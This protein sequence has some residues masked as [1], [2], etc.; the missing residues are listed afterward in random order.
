MSDLAARV[1]VVR[2][3]FQLAVDLTLPAGQVVA[4]VGPN[5]AGKTTLVL[6]LLG[7]V[8][9][10]QGRIALGPDV[11]FDAS[12]GVD[13]PTEERRIGY[14]PQDYA[15]FPHLTAADNVGFA[16]ACRAPVPP[17]RQ[18]AQRARAL[19]E[20]VGAASYADRRPADLS[21]GER[22]RVA[23]ARALATDPRALLFDEPFAALDATARAEVRAYLRARLGELAL[24]ALVITHDRDDVEALGAQVVVLES[25]RIVQQGS[26][27]QL[28]AH[29]ATAYV[30]RFCA[31]PARS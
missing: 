10:A 9:P 11:L 5:G 25:G 23:L 13:L 16:L 30:A 18:R 21:G 12:A 4:V 15:L 1:T 17:R 2:G 29:P 14:V 27:A 28:E 3:E 20:R 26:L 7:L 8:A 6:S 31:R 24:P 19:L 22:Q